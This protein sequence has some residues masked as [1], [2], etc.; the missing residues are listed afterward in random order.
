M[1]KSPR[2]ETEICQLR[3]AQT[4]S[5][6]ALLFTMEELGEI[7]AFL[8]MEFDGVLHFVAARK[9]TQTEFDDLVRQAVCK[10]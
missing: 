8:Q 3:D 6:Q 7:T 1:F 5:L 10:H 2:S 4:D 9:L